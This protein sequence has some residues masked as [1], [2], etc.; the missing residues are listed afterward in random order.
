YQDPLHGTSIFPDVQETLRILN[1]EYQNLAI[2]TQKNE[3]PARFILKEF[4]LLEYF[5]GFAFGDSLDV[6]K[7]DPMMVQLATKNFVSDRLIY[8]GDSLTDSKTA[9]KSNSIFVLFTEG[10][11]KNSVRELNPDYYF[12]EFSKLPDIIRHIQEN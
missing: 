5:S 10:Y 7:P 12:S 9:R 8:V 4:C 6:L 2:C 3:R 11:R 1:N